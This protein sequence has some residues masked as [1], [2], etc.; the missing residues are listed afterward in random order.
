M[1]VVGF[2]GKSKI[3]VVNLLFVFVFLN[4]WEFAL[5]REFINGMVLGVLIFGPITFLWF[6]K[7]LKSAMLATL[8]SIFEVTILSVFVVE[9]FEFGGALATLKSLYWAPYLL[10]AF[11][12]VIVGLRIYNAYKNAVVDDR[13]MKRSR[14]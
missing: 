13:V 3:V 10:M 4:I 14:E 7:S 12:N 8:L 1:K 2:L 6:I 11:V 5:S 9:G